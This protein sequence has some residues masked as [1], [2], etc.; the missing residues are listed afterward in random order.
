MQGARMIA[1]VA[2][3]SIRQSLLWHFPFCSW[4]GGGCGGRKSKGVQEGGQSVSKA[5]SLL[6]PDK[7]GGGQ[8]TQERMKLE[9]K[10]ELLWA[11]ECNAAS[12]IRFCNLVE[13]GKRNKEGGELK[14]KTG[15]EVKDQPFWRRGGP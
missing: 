12:M 10:S 13:L 5:H 3:A 15:G 8:V 2:R 11:G 14:T 1:M 7:L 9:R 6:P 4:G